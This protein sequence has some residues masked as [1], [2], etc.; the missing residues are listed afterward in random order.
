MAEPFDALGERRVAV[1]AAIVDIGS[2]VAAAGVE[3]ALEDVGREIVVARDRGTRVR[4]SAER[5][6][7]RRF[8]PGR[9]LGSLPIAC[10]PQAHYADGKICR[11]PR[12]VTAAALHRAKLRYGRDEPAAGVPHDFQPRPH[13]HH[14]CRQPAAQREAERP[15]GRAGG[16]QEPRSESC[17]PTRWT[18][19]CGTSS[20]KQME[21]GIDVGNDGEQRRIGFQTYVPQRMSGFAGVSKRRRGREF[22]EFPELLSYLMRRFP[23]PPKSQ[24][25]APE[26]QAEIKYRDLKP[27]T[28]ETTGFNKIADELHAFSERFM[29]AASP[30]II[31]TTMLNAHYASH[32]AYLDALAR[33][34]SNEY[35]AIH[36]AGLVLQIDAPDLAMDRTMMYRDL[37]DA[38]FVKRCERHVA[39]INKGIEGI[40]RDRVRLHICYGNWEGPHIHD[41]ALEKILPA[42]YQAKVGALSIEFSNP[43]HAHEYSALKRVPFPKDMI[44]IPGVVETTIEFRRASRSGGAAHRG[45]GGDH[46]RPRARRRLDRLRLRHLHAARMG[47]RAGGVAQAQGDP[48]RRRHRFGPA[49]GKEDGSVSELVLYDFGNSVC[50]QKVRITL[51]AK[52]L[53]WKAIPVESVHGGAIRSEISQAQSQGR[54]ADAGSRRQAGDRVDADLRI[55]RRRRFRRRRGSFPPIRGGRA[56]CGCGARWST[57][58]CSTASP[59]SASRPCSASACAPCRKKSGRSGFATSAIRAAPIASSRL[60]STAC[61]RR[62]W[63]T[64][65]RPTSAR[66]RCWRRRSPRTAGRGFSARDPSL[67]DINLMPFAARLDYLGLLDLWTEGRPQRAGTGGSAPARGRISSPGCTILISEAEFA[68]MRTHGPKIRDGVAAH[69]AALRPKR[70]AARAPLSIFH[71]I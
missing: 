70:A 1:A 9:G 31:S 8:L 27:I 45:G 63:C 71:S 26:A 28:D 10:P 30:G 29:T 18:R 61:S 34:M 5:Y 33:E 48:R 69:L 53:E 23:N 44:L 57:R 49:V 46:R 41:I 25:G 21:A 54:G 47:H 2:F 55:Y 40:P 3:I 4:S 59:K 64:R 35:Q 37:S 68:E 15:S 19:R 67:A 14:P 20:Q 17:S 51:R 43:R 42:L 60:T 39:A 7:S 36:K 11:N 56:A 24:Q 6:S 32:D 12:M 13:P 62:S 52:G 58:A 16:R 38:D 22:E 50:C 66:S 65:S